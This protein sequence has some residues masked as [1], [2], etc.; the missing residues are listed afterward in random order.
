MNIY[1]YAD[2]IAHRISRIVVLATFLILV[3]I[4]LFILK[5]SLSFL[6]SS[7]SDTILSISWRPLSKHPNFGLLP[8]ILGTLY[9][10]FFATLLA[11]PVSL[12][13][14]SFISCQVRGR[15][16]YLLL[17]MMDM[18]AGIPSVVYGL[19]GFYTVVKFLESTGKMAA[20]ESIFAAII[21]L[22]VMLIPYM[23]SSYVKAFEEVELKYGFQTQALGVSKW[24]SMTHL[25]IVIAKGHILTGCM[26][27]LSRALGETMAVMMVVGNSPILPRLF[28]KGI[29]LSGLIAL[30]MSG[31]QLDSLH[32]Q[33]LY[34]AG[35]ILLIFLLLINFL[36]RKI[37][38]W[39]KSNEI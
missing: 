16:K 31:A 35:F 11:L 37:E 24:Y 22:S 33:S 28:G 30:E 8:M 14:A 10:G 29:T 38:S 34:T 36:I 20:G 15:L 9:I 2:K 12:G 7:F 17:S 23:V 3:L 25:V 19:L 18:L 1:D 21:T 39:V 4:V 32:Y 6:G 26:L 13:C 27:A 5:E